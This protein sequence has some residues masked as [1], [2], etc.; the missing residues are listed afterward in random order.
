MN[1][2]L[3]QKIDLLQKVDNWAN[4][5]KNGRTALIEIFN[6]NWKEVIDS[7]PPIEFRP[8]R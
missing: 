6:K 3:Y 8:G 1:S 5:N 7:M 4:R 2:D